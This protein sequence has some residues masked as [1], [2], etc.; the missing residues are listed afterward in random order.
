M[1]EKMSMTEKYKS[2]IAPL[3]KKENELLD[4]IKNLF[5]REAN[6]DFST[7]AKRKK[8]RTWTLDPAETFL[9]SRWDPIMMLLLA[10]TATVTPWEVAFNGTTVLDTLFVINRVVDS[11]FVFDMCLQFFIEFQYNDT[12]G[13]IRDHK[14][15]AKKYLTG[16]FILDFVSVF[17]F[18]LLSLPI[19]TPT[20]LAAKTNA[21]ALGLPWPPVTA[22]VLEA[23]QT[24][25]RLLAKVKNRATGSSNNVS[26]IVGNITA[27]KEDDLGSLK[28]LRVVRLMRLVKL[29]RIVRSARIFKRIEASGAISFAT[30]GLIKVRKIA[31]YAKITLHRRVPR[32]RSYSIAKTQSL[33]TSQHSSDNTPFPLPHPTSAHHVPHLPTFHSIQ[34]GVML[35]MILHWLACMWNLGPQFEEESPTWHDLNALAVTCIKEGFD[36]TGANVCIQEMPPP[37]EWSPWPQWL[38]CMEFS[39][40]SM[41]MG[42]GVTAPVTDTERVLGLIIMLVGG[43]VYAYVG[44]DYGEIEIRL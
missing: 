14:L 40:Q 7:H 39:L 41:V 20:E 21:T 18:F 31:A 2:I 24:G 35:I 42:Y 23:V 6:D 37:K 5:E 12:G 19:L 4:E 10:F 8:P 34:M 25:G 27:T 11:F 15:I 3:Q 9:G 16:W 44:S 38:I 28:L 29:L 36:E 1:C 30:M 13:W 17:P 43:G 22:T 33:I 26:F 32:Y